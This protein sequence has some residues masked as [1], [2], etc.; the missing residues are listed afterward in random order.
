MKKQRFLIIAKLVALLLAIGPLSGCNYVDWE[1]IKERAANIN[2]YEKVALQLSKENRALKID[3][4]KLQTEIARLQDENK[5]LSTQLGEKRGG[6]RGIA[7]IQQVETKNDLVRF[8][9]YR[10]TPTQMLAVANA[11][12]KKGNYEK[13]AQFFRTFI[14]NFENHELL[15]DQVLFKAGMA[16]FETGKHNDWTLD[17][18]N[19]LIRGHPTSKFYRGAKLW[20]ALAMLKQGDKKAFFNTVEEFR[21]KYR[22]TDEW[23]ILSAHYEKILQNYKE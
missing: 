11:E 12:F 8:N 23:K 13:A 5:F 15:N 16:A 22:N 4:T 18:F 21:K 9:T 20:S 7:S 10:W 17:N 2:R 14:L 3:I 19:R 1:H 6:S